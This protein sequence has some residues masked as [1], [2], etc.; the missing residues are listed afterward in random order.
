MRQLAA[1]LFVVL[2]AVACSERRQPAAVDPSKPQFMGQ[3]PAT[4][5]AAGS[6]VLTDEMTM[7]NAAG[8]GAAL[9]SLGIGH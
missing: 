1:A 9:W 6:R 4:R 3:I 8:T 7:A 2:L 5:P